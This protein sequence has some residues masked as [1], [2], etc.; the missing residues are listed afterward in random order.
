MSAE[1]YSL[2]EVADLLGVSKRTLQRQ[3]RDGAFPGRFLAPSPHGMEMRI[4]A[5]DVASAGNLR[6]ALSVREASADWSADEVSVIS[7]LPAPRSEGVESRELEV[8]RDGLIELVRDERAE[9]LSEVRAVIEGR[10]TAQRQELQAMRETVGEMARQLGE[11]RSQLKV[12]TT[13]VADGESWAES[14]GGQASD[15]DV[16]GLLSELG[17][18]EAMLGVSDSE[19]K[20]L[21]GD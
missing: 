2:A 9:F 10:D 16:D 19:L 3:I 8:L 7:S 13:Q 5:A 11:L 6:G 17:E 12:E 15:L 4:P 1:S 21:G 20:N 14:L 18:L